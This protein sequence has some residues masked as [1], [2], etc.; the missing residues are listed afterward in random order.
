MTVSMYP[1]LFQEKTR[2]SVFSLKAFTIS[3]SDAPALF[4]LRYLSLHLR[5]CSMTVRLR[6]AG[7]S[8]A[9]GLCGLSLRSLKNA[10]WRSLLRC[11]TTA[12]S[13]YF[14]IL[15]LTVV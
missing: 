11:W 7:T 6:F 2:I 14:C 13:A 15:E 10:G 8:L 3:F 1:F 4:I 12:S 5:A 9:K